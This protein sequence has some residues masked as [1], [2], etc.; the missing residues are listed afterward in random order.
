[1]LMPSFSYERPT[2]L[3]AALALLQRLT[4]AK[5]PYRLCAGG[6]DL[7]PDLKRE[8][9]PIGTLISLT[10][11]EQLRGVKETSPGAFELGALT[12]LAE[13]ARDARLP[14]VVAETA[15]KIASPQ[16]RNQATLGGNLLVDNRCV[17][18]NQSPENRDVH[19][20]C[21][22]AGGE[23]CHLVPNAKR[24]SAPSQ[25]AAAC[26]SAHAPTPPTLCRARFV[27]DLAPVLMLLDAQLHL[28][29]AT[30]TRQVALRDFYLSDGIDRTKLA[31]GELLVRV[32][33]PAQGSRR[34]HYTKLRIRE[35]ID[36]P[37]L[38]VAVSWEDTAKG[39]RL[40]VA[41][42]GVN[43]HPVLLT[44]D[45]ATGQQD[46]LLEQACTEAP[47]RVA[48]LAQDFFSP[49]YRRQMIPVLIRRGLAELLPTKKVT[50]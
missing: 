35:A 28:A 9:A 29:S 48:P 25:S 7:V 20:A 31:P 15:K 45:G 23:T 40:G 6:T 26:G 33:L 41:I 5:A 16:I 32:T 24:G 21:F 49:N 12:K 43:T 42:T 17:F 19:A 38:G 2:E 27:S 1:M 39:H 30:G 50:R 46:A 14:A 13:V 10:K 34:T 37:S 3:G 44:L 36:F 47:K 11:L 22:K 4:S 18:Y 8:G